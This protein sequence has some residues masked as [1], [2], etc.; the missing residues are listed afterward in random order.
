MVMIK[1]DQQ[2]AIY[3]PVGNL[4]RCYELEKQLCVSLQRSRRS[5]SWVSLCSGIR[6]LSKFEETKILQIR[7]TSRH[8]SASGVGD[9]SSAEDA[10]SSKRANTLSLSRYSGL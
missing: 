1:E 4:V 8:S 7:Q 10:F 5:F 9:C 3:T 6:E 2:I